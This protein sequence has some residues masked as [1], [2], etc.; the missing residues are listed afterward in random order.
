MNV[1]FGLL[2]Y[3]FDAAVGLFVVYVVLLIR[4]RVD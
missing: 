1:L 2:K 3:V 4:K